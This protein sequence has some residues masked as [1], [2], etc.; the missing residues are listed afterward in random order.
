MT[1]PS[2]RRTGVSEARKIIVIPD[3]HAHPSYDVERF[4]WLGSLIETERPS[5]VVCLGDFAD[6]PSLSHYDRNKRGFEGRRYVHDIEVTRNALSALHERIANAKPH[7]IMCLGN[8][9][10]RISKATNDSAE[11]DGAIGIDDLG[12]RE[13]G[14]E[15]YP[16]Q[17][18]VSLGGI[19]FSHHF[20]SGV[21]GRPIGGMTQA[22]SMT[23]LLYQ[24]A[25][26]GHSHTYD[27]TIR[28]RPDGSRILALS[29]G[30][31]THLEHHETW[32]V[33]TEK[34][35]VNG[36]T[37]LEDVRHGWPGSWRFIS[38]ESLK[39]R[40]RRLKDLGPA[41]RHVSVA[42][43]ARIVGVRERSVRKWC[44]HHKRSPRDYVETRVSDLRR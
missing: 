5:H 28:T 12:Y 22:A 17:S 35:W 34:L 25:V 38:Q 27:Q 15:L 18:V 13:R 3:A 31:Y 7:W 44:Q 40:F 4:A 11:L 19:S 33:A 2:E 41:E 16:Y 14:W 37:I 9:E 30:C 1:H 24:S 6:M 26:A 21:S 20:A 8:H 23:R 10:A 43:A 39:A 29:A 32:S 42:D 36:I